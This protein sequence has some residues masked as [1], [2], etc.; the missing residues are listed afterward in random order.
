MQAAT[1]QPMQWWMLL[2][3]AEHLTILTYGIIPTHKPLSSAT[4]L[5]A[6][7]FTVT[8]TDDNGCTATS[9]VMVSEPALLSATVAVDNNVSCNAGADGQATVTV[10]GGT[11]NYIY[12]WDDLQSTPTAVN[13]PAGTISV[14]VTDDAG[15]TTTVSVL[16]TEPTAVTEQQQR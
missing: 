4:G 10:T 3:V 13:L 5:G 16:F 15:C 14:L 6:G 1:V 12:E 7:T 8:V 9:S 11:P 2:Q